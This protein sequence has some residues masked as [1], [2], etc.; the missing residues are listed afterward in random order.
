MGLGVIISSKLKV[1]RT[2]GGAKASLNRAL[3]AGNKP[4]TG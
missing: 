3:V 1:L 4:E 2:G